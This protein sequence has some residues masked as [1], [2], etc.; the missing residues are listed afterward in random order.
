MP[1]S[2]SIFLSLPC[3]PSCGWKVEL[4]K[5]LNRILQKIRKLEDDCLP[6]RSV[7]W[8]RKAIRAV[9]ADNFNLDVS[10]Y[11]DVLVGASHKRKTICWFYYFRGLWKLVSIFKHIFFPPLFFLTHMTHHSRQSMNAYGILTTL[12]NFLQLTRLLWSQE[13][14][15]ALC[16]FFHPKKG[17]HIH[18]LCVR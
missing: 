7:Q 16:Q 15:H 10:A 6:W 11:T 2:Q 8:T 18:K 1:L 17:H 3:L 12:C 4:F 14:C 9:S 13:V 5:G